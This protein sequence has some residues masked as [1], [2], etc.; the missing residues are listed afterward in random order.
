MAGVFENRDAYA[1][2]T[3]TGEEY[4]LKETLKLISDSGFHFVELWGDSVH[5]DSRANVNRALIRKWLKEY[6]MTVH[7]VHAPFR[8]FSQHFAS[9]RDFLAYR[10]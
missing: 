7:S 5:F 4:P 2:F 3:W 8:R 10:M 6:G 1:V 9:E